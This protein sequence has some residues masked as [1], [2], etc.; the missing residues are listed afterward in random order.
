MTKETILKTLQA[1]SIHEQG[2]H[3][4]LNLGDAEACVDLGYLEPLPG[5]GRYILTE[6]GRK[7]V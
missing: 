4:A 6:R 1:V 3:S 7:L 5:V 2:G